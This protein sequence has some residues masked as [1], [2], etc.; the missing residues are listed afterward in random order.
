M[1]YPSSLN[2]FGHD[3][4]V[5]VFSDPIE[6]VED[7]Q[8]TDV[9]LAQYDPQTTTISLMHVPDK[10]GIGGSNFIHEVIEAADVHAD[11]KLNHTQISTLAS[12]LYQA[13]VSGEVNFGRASYETVPAGKRE[14]MPS[15]FQ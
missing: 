8:K 7:G 11:L 6:V 1:I 5:K 15:M 12:V 9:V 13:F 14:Y 2:V 3:V 4:S 10:P